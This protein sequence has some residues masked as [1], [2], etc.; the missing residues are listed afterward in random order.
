LFV[1]PREATETPK[2][3]AIGAAALTGTELSL[4]E[5]AEAAFDEEEE[6]DDGVEIS[7][8]NELS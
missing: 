8:S 7:A 5:K 4:L 6:E 2:E 1:I 3:A